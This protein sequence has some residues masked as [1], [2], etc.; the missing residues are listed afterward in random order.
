MASAR[1][2][3]GPGGRGAKHS[4]ISAAVIDGGST[5]GGF[6]ATVFELGGNIVLGGSELDD[7]P[8]I[9]KPDGPAGFLGAIAAGR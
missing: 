9:G 2:R 1:P 5:G 7:P 4:C 3:H 8:P 6:G